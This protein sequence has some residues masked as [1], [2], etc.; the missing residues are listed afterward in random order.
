M[1]R[2]SSICF[3]LGHGTLESSVPK[4]V[5]SLTEP[6]SEGFFTFQFHTRNS[7]WLRDLLKT[8]QVKHRANVLGFLL[9]RFYD[10]RGGFLNLCSRMTDGD[11]FLK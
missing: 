10:K 9:F 4:S 3:G 8:V 11:N 2:S 6:C 1:L 5:S 7:T